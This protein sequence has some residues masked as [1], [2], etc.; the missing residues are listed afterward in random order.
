MGATA[1]PFDLFL[2][3]VQQ[4]PDILE[5][6]DQFSLFAFLLYDLERDYDFHE[7]L[8]KEFD[9]LDN[10]TG[11]NLLFVAPIQS[12][13]KSERYRV[14]SNRPF[15]QKIQDKHPHLFTIIVGTEE[16]NQV[17]IPLHHAVL[18]Y[19]GLDRNAPP[20]ILL[21]SNPKENGYVTMYTSVADVTEHLHQLKEVAD[22]LV[23]KGKSNKLLKKLLVTED[24]DFETSGKWTAWKDELLGENLHLLSD[25]VTKSRTQESKRETRFYGRDQNEDFLDTLQHM[26][27]QLEDVS[28]NLVGYVHEEDPQTLQKLKTLH[29]QILD[30][31]S[32]RMLH[33]EHEKKQNKER[34]SYPS[35][36]FE[37]NTPSHSIFDRDGNIHD[38]YLRLQIFDIDWFLEHRLT[39]WDVEARSMFQSA[40]YAILQFR[41]F[42]KN[43]QFDPNFGVS[44]ILSGL[45]AAFEREMNSSLTHF[46]RQILHIDLPKN[47]WKYDEIAGQK[48]A[49]DTVGKIN[50]NQKRNH[51]S[52][53]ENWEALTLGRLRV[54]V[55]NNFLEGFPVCARRMLEIWQ[56]IKDIRNRA[57]HGAYLTWIDVDIMLNYYK[58]WCEI[59]DSHEIA[60]RSWYAFKRTLST[61]QNHQLE[62]N[63]L[64]EISKNSR[65]VEEL[66]KL[67]RQENIKYLRFILSRDFDNATMDIIFGEFVQISS[68]I[69]EQLLKERIEIHITEAWIQKC[70]EYKI[71]SDL[72]LSYPTFPSH[73]RSEIL[74]NT[75]NLQQKTISFILKNANL[76]ESQW[77]DAFRYYLQNRQTSFNWQMF[78]EFLQNPIFHSVCCQKITKHELALQF[79]PIESLIFR[80]IENT[81]TRRSYSKT[82][83]EFVIQCFVS[84]DMISKIICTT[85]DYLH[86][87]KILQDEF[88]KQGVLDWKKTLAR[89]VSSEHFLSNIVLQEEPALAV[90]F[91]QNKSI[92][93]LVYQILE[94]QGK[95]DTIPSNSQYDEETYI[96]RWNSYNQEQRKTMLKRE[97]IPLQVILKHFGSE[98]ISSADILPKIDASFAEAHMELLQKISEPTIQTLVFLLQ[99][100]LI[101]PISKKLPFQTQVDFEKFVVETYMWNM[102]VYLE[103]NPKFLQDFLLKQAN[104]N[105]SYCSPKILQEHMAKI[106]PFCENI[107]KLHLP[108]LPTHENWKHIRFP[109]VTKLTWKTKTIEFDVLEMFPNM[110][111]LEIRNMTKMECTQ[112]L[113]NI[114]FLHIVE[115]PELE[116]INLQS[117]TNLLQFQ[118]RQ[119]PQLK[120]ILGWEHLTCIQKVFVYT[121]HIDDL[122]F[123]KN[124]PTLVQYK[125]NKISWKR[126][127]EDE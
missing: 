31:L 75:A 78:G 116:E 72:L 88:G 28:R 51:W 104:L 63:I 114:E 65:N 105:L 30:L 23:V 85:E 19:L 9:N 17:N 7:Y 86:I 46:I 70:W 52:G 122:T 101:S 4:D 66:Q 123:L 44:L 111:N 27:G 1:K 45:A 60:Q 61:K 47:Y 64:E 108:E 12:N 67:I 36:I 5:A 99:N 24:I 32:F 21:C 100:K 71:H 109:S 77:F 79:I 124:K 74:Q 95:L 18:S 126:P 106:L 14:L 40:M 91:A 127:E 121:P 3:F 84:K 49:E 13:I 97:N 33:Q 82:C 96:Y 37:Q 38:L 93:L 92:S 62:I 55:Q 16:E 69:Q 115:S 76:T 102:N 20:T 50:I 2:L 81:P 54:F 42:E 110:K 73:I 119:T 22:S 120:N 6:L 43:Y 94:G 35:K 15:M 68:I 10:E 53:E 48:Y 118:V 89:S 58:E 87:S 59:P 113:P 83:L 39:Y 11:K 117:F 57:T 103:H 125:C 80:L 25:V 107:Q 34:N 29:F 90:I 98:W 41:N 8:K 56:Q 26:L 112:K